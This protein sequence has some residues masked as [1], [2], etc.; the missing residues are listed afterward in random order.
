MCGI[1]GKVGPGPASET[2][3]L[4]MCDAIA[5]RG[6]DDHGTFVEGGTGL[7]M[8]RLSIIDI[9]GGHQPLTN[10]DGSVVVVFNG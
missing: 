4:R 1:V 10:E 2:E 5:H 3:I 8:R 9:A 6:P 7:G